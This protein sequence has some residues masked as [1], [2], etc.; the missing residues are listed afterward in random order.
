MAQECQKYGEIE[1][2]GIFE[3]TEAGFPDDQAVRIFVKMGSLQAA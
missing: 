1:D 2:F 3:A